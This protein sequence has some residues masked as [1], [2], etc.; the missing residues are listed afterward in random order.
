MKYLRKFA[1]EAEIFVVNRPN[2][3]LVG[4]T[5]KVLYNVDSSGAY[6]QHINGELYTTESWSA[7]GFANEEANGVAVIKDEHSFV[8]SKTHLSTTKWANVTDVLIE[9]ATSV[10]GYDNTQAIIKVATYGAANTCVKYAFPNG[11]NGYL[12]SLAEWRAAYSFKAEVDAALV[13]IGGDAINP[14]NLWTS[15]QNG[16]SFAYTMKWESGTTSG[17]GKG[18][19][20]YPR[21]FAPLNI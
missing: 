5:E 18:N 10:Y 12:A 2:V 13:L 4:D 6:I 3:V 17:A 11:E 19:N 20:G 8:I 21:P 16:A 9:G 14:T 7:M 15:S 1:T